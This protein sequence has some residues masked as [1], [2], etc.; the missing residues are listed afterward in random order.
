MDKDIKYFDMFLKNKSDADK[1]VQIVLD[2][3]IEGIWFGGINLTKPPQHTKIQSP[4]KPF[5]YQFQSQ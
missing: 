4:H 1:A 5:Q 2:K 3:V